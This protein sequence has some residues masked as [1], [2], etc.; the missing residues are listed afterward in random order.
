MNKYFIFL[1]LC[2][3]E[4]QS[5][6]Q[7][8]LL[9]S[10][11]RS[12]GIKSMSYVNL[13]YQ[14]ISLP[15]IEIPLI[16]TNYSVSKLQTIRAIEE[17]TDSLRKEQKREYRGEVI[18]VL[19]QKII[20]YE[21]KLEELKKQNSTIIDSLQ[22]QTIQLKHGQAKLQLELVEHTIK[23]LKDSLVKQ[24]EKIDALEKIWVKQEWRVNNKII[25]RE[26]DSLMFILFGK[27]TLQINAMKTKY[28]QL[29]P[30]LDSIEIHFSQLKNKEQ[31]LGNMLESGVFKAL[32]GW[33]Y[34][35]NNE[36][37]KLNKT[38]AAEVKN[39]N[40]NVL[41]TV[42]IISEKQKEYNTIENEIK[43]IYKKYKEDQ[44]DESGD[45]K[46]IANF[47]QPIA[48][49]GKLVPQITVLGFKEENSP[50]KVVAYNL[51][52]FV[53][54]SETKST[55][56]SEY[57]IFIPEASTYGFMADFS[58]GFAP[59]AGTVKGK[60]L[61]INFGGYYLGKSIIRSKDSTSFNIGLLQ[62]KTG[63]QYIVVKNA[64][65]IY[66][67]FNPYFVANGNQNFKSVYTDYSNKLNLFTDFGVDC[68]LNLAKSQKDFFLN[69]DLGFI[70]KG[71]DVSSIIK[72][73]DV[74]IPRIKIGLVKS[75]G[76]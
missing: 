61:G 24:N 26:D 7:S 68:Y 44:K 40:N 16:E 67:N 23:Q 18:K 17:I 38:F 63:I 66:L 5:F 76:F 29:Q 50:N 3:I 71:G 12:G 69:F 55:I 51:K 48:D 35:A 41:T 33:L 57:R 70:T 13:S 72:N 1:C 27:L 20:Q 59:I 37:E 52:L 2:I 73:E 19:N 30:Q 60:R 31:K 62:F 54:A 28:D 43:N 21:S 49:E 6:S 39:F 32:E 22:Y 34:Y 65:S 9:Q 64:L 4:L 11:A 15:A 45:L 25:S 14:P 75:F 47:T 36:I 58:L 74:L 53:S 42:N 8:P 10:N 56:N 46:A